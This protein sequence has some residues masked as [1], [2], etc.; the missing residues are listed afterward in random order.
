MKIITQMITVL[1]NEHLFKNDG[2]NDYFTFCFR[3]LRS[4]KHLFKRKTIG[5]VK[6]KLLKTKNETTKL[7]QP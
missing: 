3:F 6:V 2:T 5:K 4:F 1:G 7:K